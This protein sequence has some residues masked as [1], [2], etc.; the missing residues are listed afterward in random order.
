MPVCFT[1]IR[2]NPHYPTNFTTLMGDHG[3]GYNVLNHLL[4]SKHKLFMSASIIKNTN[5]FLPWLVIYLGLG[6][7]V[8]ISPSSQSANKKLQV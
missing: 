6:Y 1:K 3:Q 7:N 5:L 4:P 2:P 8:N